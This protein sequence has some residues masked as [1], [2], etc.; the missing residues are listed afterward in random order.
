MIH[1]VQMLGAQR[2]QTTEL[3][4]Q[5]LDLVVDA[6]RYG[7][8]GEELGQGPI[9]AL[10]GCAV[11]RVDVDDKCVVCEPLGVELIKDLEGLR[12]RVL[13]E[14]RVHLHKANLEGR[15]V[16]GD[17]CPLDHRWIDRRQLR[18]AGDP[19]HVL[20]L[21]VRDLAQRF[22]AHVE[23]SLVFVCP[24][25]RNLVWTV[26][27]TRSVVDEERPL[28]S[29]CAIVPDEL[30]GLVRKVL[31]EVV[32]FLGGER[33][34]DGDVVLEQPGVKLLRFPRQE[35]VEVR[36]TQARRVLVE[37]PR[38]GEVR[39]RR[40]V[41]LA[42]ARGVVAVGAEDL[43][44]CGGGLGDPAS[45]PGEAG[46]GLGDLPRADGV[47]VPAR[48]QRRPRRGADGHVVEA[49]VGDASGVDL[50]QSWRVNWPA[51]RIRVAVPRV[52]VHDEDDV[53]GILVQGLPLRRPRVDGVLE[54]GPHDARGRHRGERQVR[55]RQLPVGDRRLS[56]RADGDGDTLFRAAHAAREQQW[57]R[58]RAHERR[59]ASLPL[60]GGVALGVRAG[61]LA[62]LE[63]EGGCT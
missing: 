59:H 1:V 44:D 21:L 35:A 56:I 49:V 6:R 12:V 15:L 9:Q 45:V 16:G 7:V 51:E 53:R 58:G 50:G 41:P 27:G 60:L 3:A 24:S 31:C 34:L 61:C 11:V 36:E 52:V 10:R 32:A 37:R 30:D 33:R 40:V 54:R 14:A 57:E 26:C 17:I 23:L 5:R 63:P 8:L 48:Q 22:P 62:C 20:L 42:E 47:V 39:D 25:Q 28:G 29:E 19:T 18:I 46:G 2:V 55:G 38:L 4:V 13:E 43:G